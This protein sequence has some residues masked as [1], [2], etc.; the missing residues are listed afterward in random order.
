MDL[1]LKQEDVANIINVTTDTITNWENSRSRPQVNSY[2]RIVQFLG[3][4]PFKNDDNNIADRIKNYRFEHGLSLEAFGQIVG[5]DASTIVAWEN[6]KVI[7]PKYY[8]GMLK[9]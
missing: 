1:G 5:K 7:P 9:F 8:V 2:P 4:N 3:Y 6:G